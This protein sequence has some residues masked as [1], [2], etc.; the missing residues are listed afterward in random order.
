MEDAFKTLQQIVT[1]ILN[2]D[3]KY[4]LIYQNVYVKV[5]KAWLVKVKANICFLFQCCL[6]I[7]ANKLKKQQFQ[8][9]TDEDIKTDP[10]E[11]IKLNLE[12]FLFYSNVSFNFQKPRHQPQFVAWELKS[13]RIFPQ[14]FWQILEGILELESYH[15]V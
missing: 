6:V 9:L 13:C 3:L 2:T 10:E 5:F 7:N 4:K 1:F 12:R 14:L 8:L 11:A 15:L